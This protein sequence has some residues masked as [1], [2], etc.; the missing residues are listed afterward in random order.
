MR[1]R[2]LLY[3]VVCWIAGNAAASMLPAGRILAAWA[4]VSLLLAAALMSGRWSWKH[5]IMLWVTLVLGGANWEWNDFRNVSVLPQAL[6]MPSARLEELAVAA[7]GTIVSTVERDGDRVDFTVKLD[8]IR[9]SGSPAASLSNGGEDKS[10]TPTSPDGTIGSGH[11]AV[12]GPT[13]GETIAVQLKLQAEQEIAVVASWRRGDRVILNGT[14]TSPPGARNFG[15]FDYR[16]YLRN[17]HIHWLLKVAGTGQVDASPPA[18]RSFRTL[19]RWNDDVR[20][21]LGAELESL[22]RKKDAGYLK[23]LIIGMQDELDPATYRQFSRLG[24]THI[25]A[26]S[27]MHV[28]VYAGFLLFLLS[29]LRFTRET[30]LTVTLLLVP[31]YVLLSGAGPSVVRAGLMSMITLYAARMGVLKDGMHILAAS[32]LLMLVWEPYFLQN[33]SFQLSF[34]V[35]AGLMVYVPHAMPLV[36]ALPRRLGSAVAVTL[37]AQLVSFPLTIYYFNQFA[38]LSFA[39]NLVLVPFITFA[40]LPTGTAALL[41]GRIWPAGAKALAH[42]VEWMNDAT[43]Y[44][45]EWTGRYAGITIWRSPSLL[46]IALYYTLLYALLRVLKYHAEIWDAPLYAED[47]TRPLKGLQPSSKAPHSAAAFPGDL[48]RA[49]TLIRY[50]IAAAVLAGGFAILL[51]AGYRPERLSPGGSVSFLDVGQGDSMLITTPEGAHILVDGGGTM[52]YGSKEAWR[53]RRSPYEVGAK[54]L[55][56]L[57]KKRGI[58]RLDAVIL[59]HGDQDHAGGLQA[60]LEE[61]PVS[62]LLFNGTLAERE[63]YIK[64]MKTALDRGVKLYGVHRG[65]DLS[66][67]GSAKLS[68]LWPEPL[69]PAGTKVPVLEKQNPASVVFRLDISG[70]SFLF[71]G[72]IDTESEER[73]ISA[74]RASR[75]TAFPVDV[76]K[77]AHHGSKSSTGGV[78]L[79]FWKPRAAVI[80]AGVNNLYGHPN[81]EVLERLSAA[82]TTVFRTDQHGEI[83]MRVL[84]EGI[85]VRHKLEGK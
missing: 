55:V 59:T 39:A 51:Y 64:L 32:A 57:L 9:S 18:A 38:L 47:E 80:S 16:A 27:G 10:A 74:V 13:H 73:M 65:M 67:D 7:E 78:W 1:K 62:A 3:V 6:G 5:L 28:A 45:V 53:I 29:R 30:A 33:V 23:G 49:R 85:S 50:R 61:I 76:L 82:R 52:S 48:E 46:W 40:V 19:L 42:A 22:F 24:L 84:P 4:G 63:E 8:S 58:H 17:R 25:L 11:A 12:A 79:E 34:L 35:T 15:G 66:P 26:I 36:A 68:F 75:E 31:A 41:L 44:A 72:D 2:P 77:V 21:Q 20:A 71:T 81:G 43:F 56:P 37:V 70:T 54:T 60:V 69:N 83:Q 14:L